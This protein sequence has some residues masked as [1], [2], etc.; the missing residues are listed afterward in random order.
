MS[1]LGRFQVVARVSDMAGETTSPHTGDPTTQF[2][3]LLCA[4]VEARGAGVGVGGSEADTG[5]LVVII[6]VQCPG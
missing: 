6:L 4:E 3:Q 5:S 1:G 2:S